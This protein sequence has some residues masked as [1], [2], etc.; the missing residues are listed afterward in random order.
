MPFRTKDPLQLPAPPSPMTPIILMSYLETIVDRH[1]V[2]TSPIMIGGSP[3]VNATVV[4][5]HILLRTWVDEL[6]ENPP[7]RDHHPVQHRD[8]KP[9]WCET[10]LLTADWKNP[11]P[12]RDNA[13][14]PA[15]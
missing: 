12:P 11:H 1:E 5:G 2:E 9:P 7:C 10:C 14:N 4:D 6:N 13:P 3:L 15:A 8:A